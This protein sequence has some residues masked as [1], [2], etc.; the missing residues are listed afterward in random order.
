MKFAGLLAVAWFAC[1]TA[2]AEDS[3]DH[4]AHCG[5]NCCC[6]KV[7]RVV[8]T[9]KKVPKTTYTCECEDFCVPGKSEHCVTRDE[10]GK[11]KHVYTPTCAYV[12][13]KKKLVKHETNQEVPTYKW[14]VEYL[15]DNCAHRC[16]MNEA[17]ASTAGL[18]APIPS[19]QPAAPPMPTAGAQVD[20]PSKSSAISNPLRRALDPIFGQK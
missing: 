20:A 5:C 16:A 8:C 14:V 15:C 2:L 19:V 1:A 4:C 6:Q 10:C 7:C 18:S 9:T 12:R 17:A 11:K 3:T 13:T